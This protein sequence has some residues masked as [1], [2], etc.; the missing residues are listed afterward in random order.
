MKSQTGT[1][2]PIEFVWP[3]HQRHEWIDTQSIPMDGPKKSGTF[4]VA[5][6]DAAGDF[7]KPLENATGLFKN[8]GLLKLKKS[9]IQK[10]AD[11]YGML[12]IWKP[13]AGKQVARGKIM[14]SGEDHEL[15]LEEVDRMRSALELWDAIVAYRN[16][17]KSDLRKLIEWRDRSSVLYQKGESWAWIATPH[18]PEV[19]EKLQYPELVQPALRHLQRLLNENLKRHQ[20]LAQLLWSQTELRIF[21]RP[22][23]LIAA[24]WLQF[25]L[26]ID[27]DRQYRT[28]MEC[29]RWFEVGGPNKRSD[30]ETC[31]VTCRKRRQNKRRESASNGTRKT[32]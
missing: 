10:F 5:A 9:A 19:L 13:V 25:A 23:S 31:D 28:C 14:T 1:H 32:R 22:T 7:Y 26:A 15:W 2:K 21:V 30:A 3:R 20:S 24:M 17:S 29:G 16:G 18:E 12:G 27:G 8:F 11:K 6:G 4:L